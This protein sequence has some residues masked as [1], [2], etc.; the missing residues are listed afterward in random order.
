MRNLISARTFAEVA[1]RAIPLIVCGVAL[2]VGSAALAQEGPGGGTGG[3]QRNRPGRSLE[4]MRNDFA[5]E[6][7]RSASDLA[8]LVDSPTPRHRVGAYLARSEQHR[9]QALALARLARCGAAFPHGA[10][11]RIREALR[12]DL[13]TWRDA[14]QV[15]GPEWL[16]IRDAWLVE[17]HALTAGEWAQ[18]RAFW[19]QERDAWLAGR[20]ELTG[21]LRPQRREAPRLAAGG[22]AGLALAPKDERIGRVL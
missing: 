13:H 8:D 19:F 9:A 12:F 15:S 4:D 11:E 21:A 6:S 10:A 17:R 22:C 2:V 7:R 20:R 3:A 14:F 5:A 18:R 16:A 1:M